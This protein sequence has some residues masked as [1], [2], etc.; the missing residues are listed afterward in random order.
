VLEADPSQRSRLRN[1]ADPEM[2]NEVEG[3]LSLTAS[4]GSPLERDVLSH[5][6]ALLAH[7][8]E[9]IFQS[10]ESGGR[11]KFGVCL[12]AEAWVRFT[13]RTIRS[14]AATWLSK[15]CRRIRGRSGAP[16]ALP[17]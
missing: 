9:T 5:A 15:R 4:D 2:R 8:T 14:S 7:G 13:A 16:V 17:P 1:S 6:G 10:D 11:T 12:A 3:L